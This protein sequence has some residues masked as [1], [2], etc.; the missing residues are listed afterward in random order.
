MWP[1]VSLF[2]TLCLLALAGLVVALRRQLL[3]ARQER[4]EIV[5]EER[6]MFDFLHGL[7]E[8]LAHDDPEEEMYRLI[9]DGA[10]TVA[11]TIG[12][13]IYIYDAAKDVLLPAFASPTCP[14]LVE[15]PERIIERARSNPQ[16]LGSFL[17]LHGV[18]TDEGV[19]GKVF[20]SQEP[21]LV[22][23][24]ANSG[25]LENACN[26]HQLH[27]RCMVAP[28]SSGGNRYG[29][30]A[31]ADDR[32]DRSFTEN[33]YEV[34]RSVAEQ[35]SYAIASARIHQE[36][37]EKRRMEDE[38]RNA[39]EIQRVLLPKSDPT[40]ADYRFAAINLPAKV[41]S[42]D[43]YDYVPI[44]EHRY[45][46]TLGDVSGKGLPASLV[47]AITRSALR[48]NA[49]PDSPPSEVLARVNQSIF[50]DIREDMFITKLFLILD[51]RTSS[52]SLA[53]AGHNPPL[54]FSRE[55]GEVT[56][57]EPRGMAIGVDAG[58]VFQRMITDTSVEMAVGDCLLLYTDGASEALDVNGREFDV[59]RLIDEFREAAPRGADEVVA[60]LEAVLKDFTTGLPQA[61]D[62]TLI[63]IEKR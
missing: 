46:V 28:L 38:L 48:A 44:D 27:V 4:E 60:H 14:P 54:H 8:A 42:G 3:A 45:G 37:V 31:V 33:D 13:T 47:A 49:D 53:R 61:D 16:T 55:S 32:L 12:G 9:V 51:R 21:R 30:L 24:L 2:L 5:G 10:S 22:E 20:T 59:P 43:Y 34:F 29:V 18:P 23:G 52:I 11:D 17:K 1:T 25:L 36:A 41:L 57:I 6:R 50:P 56:E 63:A 26:T 40:L 19:L 39:S 7:G 62:I 58:K 15:L 35:S